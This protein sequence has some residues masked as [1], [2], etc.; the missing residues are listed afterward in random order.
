MS[1]AVLTTDG[2]YLT[3]EE[4][5]ASEPLSEVKREYLGGQVYAM[6]GA[7][8]PHNIIASNLA[9]ML[10]N[11]LRGQ[12]CR[13]FGSDMRLRLQQPGG[14]YF[15]YP[16]AMIACDPTDVGKG[17]R[18]RP[19]AL[20]EILS[21]S[22]RQIDAREKRAAYLGLGSLDAYVR[23]EQ[24]RAEVIVERRTSNG[25]WQMERHLGVAATVRLPGKLGMIEL[26]LAE[27]YE[28]VTL[29]SPVAADSAPASEPG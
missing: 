10:Y 2:C 27:L 8:D 19:A 26:P 15:Y 24:A 16:D 7:S 3:V 29:P 28:G 5:L 13:P 1:T 25:G 12:Q 6:A 4:Y 21:D 18:E 14:T 22:T 17:W 9:G 23:I 11:C 20:F